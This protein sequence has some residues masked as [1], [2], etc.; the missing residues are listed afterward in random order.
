MTKSSRRPK[1]NHHPHP[2]TGTFGA[3]AH[4]PSAATHA[5]TIIHTATH[6]H[7]HACAAA[8]AR[9]AA[10]AS[11]ARLAATAS[12]A[13]LAAAAATA[14]SPVHLASPIRPASPIPTAEDKGELWHSLSDSDD[15]RWHWSDGLPE[16]S[17]VRPSVQCALALPVACE[18]PTTQLPDMTQCKLSYIDVTLVHKCGKLASPQCDYCSVALSANPGR[19]MPHFSAC[20]VLDGWSSGGCTNCH[21]HNTNPHCSFHCKYKL[22]IEKS[23][24]TTEQHH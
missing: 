21:W 13:R 18:I 10:A 14:I 1:E 16:D 20:V 3:F 2:T 4:H 12:A 7:A 9:L 23:V 22:V 5:A 11:A 19:K 24:L 8:A 17:H 15:V 6:A